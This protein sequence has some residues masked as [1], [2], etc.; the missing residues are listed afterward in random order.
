MNIHIDPILR[1]DFESTEHSLRSKTELK[2]WWN[3]PFII[4]ITT[5]FDS[6]V[7]A[8]VER[9]S[10]QYDVRCLDGGA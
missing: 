7:G 5:R 6:E 4:T 9:E 8:W 2:R 10:N 1:V 3:R